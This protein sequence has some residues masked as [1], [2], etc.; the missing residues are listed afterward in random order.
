MSPKDADA[1]STAARGADGVTR[2]VWRTRSRNQ[3]ERASSTLTWE[4]VHITSRA[5]QQLLARSIDEPRDHP[6]ARLERRSWL[7]GGGGIMTRS[8]AVG[9]V[10]IAGLAG[11]AVVAILLGWDH[12]IY[13]G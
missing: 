8:R 7:D 2:S 3:Q 12:A 4:N 10:A 9:V 6:P 11:L 1:L 5:A 13:R